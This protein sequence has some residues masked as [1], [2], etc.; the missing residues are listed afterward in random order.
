MVGGIESIGGTVQESARGTGVA[1]ESA[2]LLVE[3]METI[4]D[5][6]EENREIS[7]KLRK[8]V[9]KFKRI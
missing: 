5:E 9:E 1:A 6:A 8:Q 7:R 2:N 4:R 3:A